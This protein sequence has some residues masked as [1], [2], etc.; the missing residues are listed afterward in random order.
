MFSLLRAIL[1]CLA[2]MV[3]A[4]ARASAKYERVGDILAV[5]AGT[6]HSLESTL[7]PRERAGEH[8]E[9]PHDGQ[10]AKLST[11]TRTPK[12]ELARVHGARRRA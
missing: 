7:W 3:L 2:L 11:N 5:N 4:A 12:A 8:G 6:C 9:G 1:T 10:V